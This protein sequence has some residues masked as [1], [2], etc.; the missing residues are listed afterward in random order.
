MIKMSTAKF[1]LLLALPLLLLTWGCS[2]TSVDTAIT[3][4]PVVQAYLIPG[5]TITVRLYLQKQ[6]TD[7]AKY[8]A[9]LTGQSVYISDGSTNILL[10]ESAAGVYTHADGGFLAAGKTYTMQFKYLTYNVSASTVMPAQPTNLAITDTVIN[11]SHATTTP[12]SA[13]DTL[14]RLTWNNPSQFNHIIV[15]DNYLA[16]RTL[17]VRSGFGGG[18][19]FDNSTN[20]SSEV[21]AGK[22]SGYAITQNTL[23]FYAQ[24]KVILYR[25]NQEYL[26]MLQSNSN[27]GNTSSQ[28]LTNTY[29]NVTNGFGI[30][31]AMQVAN[32]VTLHA[33]YTV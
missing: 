31:T 17:P 8:G 23:P 14:A 12:N 15:F 20:G 5:Q 30:F 19:N 7:T 18:G 9:P 29:T 2:K 3:D 13:P 32:I 27:N 28:T 1:Y 25:V 33:Y 21:N 22:A 6:T 26:D 24:Y 11:I 16:N 10:T 4:Q